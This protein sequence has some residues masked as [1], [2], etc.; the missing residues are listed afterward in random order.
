MSLELGHSQTTRAQIEKMQANGRN[1]E[2]R[3]FDSLR[4]YEALEVN[5]LNEGNYGDNNAG[6]TR[7][8]WWGV[9]GGRG[10]VMEIIKSGVWE[11][12]LKKI[13]AAFDAFSVP[14]PQSIRRS[15]ARGEFGDELDIHRVYAGQ[16]DTAWSRRV[17]KVRAK[18]AQKTLFF[19]LIHSGG[20]TAEEIFWRGAA[21]VKLADALTAAGYSVE[22]VGHHGTYA[23]GSAA[24][25]R[26]T[27][28]SHSMPLDLPALTLI[29]CL[30]GYSRSVGFKAICSVDF[31]VDSGLGNADYTAPREWTG[32]DT[33][34][35][36]YRVSDKESAIRFVQQRI[37]ELTNNNAE[38]A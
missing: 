20:T 1:A 7:T 4:D 22:I 16:L 5:P 25:D 19:P 36:F 31:R 18:I 13:S 26:V 6:T 35:D 9:K 32:P 15:L 34:Q 27:V 10:A 8:E 37:A 28:K 24:Y 29:A 2:I 14:T 21:M 17:R 23:N 12:G 38:A 33:V 11:D 3:V 30:S